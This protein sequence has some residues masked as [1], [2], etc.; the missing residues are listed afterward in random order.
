LDSELRAVMA[1]RWLPEFG[2]LGHSGAHL[3]IMRGLFTMT[4]PTFGECIERKK[5]MKKVI[6]E[7]VSRMQD[8]VTPCRPSEGYSEEL[9]IDLAQHVKV[10]EFSGELKSSDQAFPFGAPD[11]NFVKVGNSLYEKKRH[12]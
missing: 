6:A 3:A 8:N 2:Y 10:A 9:E 1:S 4:V 11:P 12:P 7:R 5:A